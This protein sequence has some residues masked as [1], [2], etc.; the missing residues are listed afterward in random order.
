MTGGDGFWAGA[1]GAYLMILDDDADD[2]S[3]VTVEGGAARAIHARSAGALFA[4]GDTIE[5]CDRD[6]CAVE[7]EATA[8][9]LRAAW[10][11]GRGTVLAAGDGVI[12]ERRW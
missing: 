6:G 1:G 7:A 3:L 10:G 9:G 8:K 12:L 4:V 2:P 5:A 11:D